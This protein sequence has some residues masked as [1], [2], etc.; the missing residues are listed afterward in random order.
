MSP[1]DPKLTSSSLPLLWSDRYDAHDALGIIM[2]R[3]QFIGFLG[4]TVIVWP[5]RSLTQNDLDLPLV[6]VLV[7]ATEEMA[8][9]RIGALRTGLR[10]EGFVEGKHHALAVRYGEGD[11]RRFPQLVK[12]LDVQKP[13][14]FV[15]TA[16]VVKV[17]HDLLP[18]TPT[19][20]TAL[21]ADPIQLGYARSYSKPGGMMTGNI[22]NAIGGEESLI[23]KRIGFLKELVPNLARLGL[24]APETGQIPSL[25]KNALQR[26]SV[27]FGFEFKHYA[28]KSI[29]DLESAFPAGLSDNVSAFYVS[30]DAFLTANI[31]KVM[32]QVVSAGRPTIGAYPEWGR[33][34]LLMAYSTDFLDGYRR[35][36]IYVA[37]IIQGARPG[38]LPIEQ[39]SKF[40]LVLNLKTAKQLG[41][42]VPSTLQRSG[43]SS[44]FA[45]SPTW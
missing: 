33:A 8:Q 27:H 30:G 40:T 38:D 36:G 11:P 26:A 44:V 1:F 14:V 10:E 45:P 42:N 18:N 7:A 28:I 41:I 34:G 25:E 9:D 3:R 17:V 5:C 6:A 23:E 31:S 20:F 15:A 4:G 21:A 29:A 35:A 24:I 2:R 13:R 12:D 16:N 39:E 32:P 37:K 43:V 22:M 19:V